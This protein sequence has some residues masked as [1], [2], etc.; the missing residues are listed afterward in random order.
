MPEAVENDSSY[1]SICRH[2]RRAPHRPTAAPPASF[3]RAAR[4]AAA[5]GRARLRTR[6]HAR[7]AARWCCSSR[8]TTTSSCSMAASFPP[9]ATWRASAR[10][11]NFEE[12]FWSRVMLVRYKDNNAGHAYCVWQTDGQIFG[13]DRAGGSF[14]DPR[15]FARSRRHRAVARAQ[16]REGDEEADA[17]RARRVHRAEARKA[18]CLLAAAAL[19]RLIA[20]PSRSMSEITAKSKFA[21]PACGGEAQWNPAKQA[22]VC[23]YCGTVAPGELQGRRLRH[24]RERPRR[25]AAQCRTTASAAG[26]PRRPR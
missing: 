5:D 1:G 3:V 14:P 22:L 11:T 6:L 21:C 2:A 4:R 10:R 20:A 19:R 18:V 8:T 26:R 15:Q 25:R 17:R 24:R 16:R 12:N 7:A 13:Y 9:A 23:P